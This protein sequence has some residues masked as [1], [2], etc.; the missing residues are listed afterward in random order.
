MTG[1]VGYASERA[2]F[3]L[4]GG[5]AWSH[6]EFDFQVIETSSLLGSSRS[7]SFNSDADRWGWTVGTGFEYALS[8][9]V[10]AF[11][12]YNYLAFGSQAT[13]LAC[14]SATIN[15]T[16]Q[17]CATIANALV[18]TNQQINQVKLGLNVRF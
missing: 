17:P 12:E 7:G 3:Y 2:L 5:V 14:T 18:D 6:N 13:S 8:N 4:K 15:T 10:T 16:P 11:A 1:R 9:N